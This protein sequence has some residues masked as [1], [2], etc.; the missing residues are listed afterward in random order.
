MV[1]PKQPAAKIP[2]GKGTGKINRAYFVRQNLFNLKEEVFTQVFFDYPKAL[3]VVNDATLLDSDKDFYYFK[4]TTLGSDFEWA[5][6]VQPE[7]SFR[8]HTI[9]SRRVGDTE[10]RREDGTVVMAELRK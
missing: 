4:M 2:N 7:G 8:D 3:A 9:W 6:S 5:F 1:Q 10:W